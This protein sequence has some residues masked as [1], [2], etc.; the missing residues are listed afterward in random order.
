MENVY[1]EQNFPSYNPAYPPPQAHPGYT[2]QEYCPPAY[3]GSRVASGNPLSVSPAPPGTGFT[4]G[5]SLPQDDPPPEYS[6]SFADAPYSAFSEKAIRRAFIRKVYLILMA[7]LIVTVGFICMFVYWDT[8]NGWVWK[9]PWFTYTLIPMLFVL[10]IILSCFEN[11][12]RQVPMNFIFLGLFTVVEGLMLGAT[13]V[14]FTADAVMW[15]VGATAFV[16]FGLSVFAMQTKVDFTKAAGI[17]WVICLSLI[18]FGILCA[19]IRSRWLHIVYASIGTLIFAVYLVIDTQM[20]L[21][22]NH[23]YSISP[24]EYV[25]AALNLYLDVI[26]MFLFILQ[27]IG[28]S[29]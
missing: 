25:F 16:S 27:L 14:F 26:N 8:L 7:Q 18:T 5:P 20:M 11:A 24:E 3:S 29:K 15:A 9:N 10:I 2:P 28:L 6:N 22:G 23:K 1:R 19:I 4:G 12:R 13:T 21:G 17:I